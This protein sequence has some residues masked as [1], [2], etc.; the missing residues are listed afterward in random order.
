MTELNMA[1]PQML[2]ALRSAK[3]QEEERQPNQPLPTARRQPTATKQP[4]KVSKQFQFSF[5]YKVHFL[6][7]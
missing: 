2:K 3:L 1:L 6:V 5:L 7:E 4:K